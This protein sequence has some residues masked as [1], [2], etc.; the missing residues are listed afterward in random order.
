MLLLYRLLLW[1]PSTEEGASR[2]TEVE[3]IKVGREDLRWH[4]CPGRPSDD[5]HEAGLVELLN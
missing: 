1:T 5:D 3:Q 4:G 2:S